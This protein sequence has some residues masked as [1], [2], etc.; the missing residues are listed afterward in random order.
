MFL[1]SHEAFIQNN[2]YSSLALHSTHGMK[3]KHSLLAAL[4]STVVADVLMFMAMAAVFTCYFLSNEYF[5]KSLCTDLF[6]QE[7]PARS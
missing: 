7:E 2:I 3:V 4:V 6:Y 1:L 5:A